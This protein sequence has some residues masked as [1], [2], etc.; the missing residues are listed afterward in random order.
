MK[1]HRR[2]ADH[3]TDPATAAL[4]APSPPRSPTISSSVEDSAVT[5]L[6]RGA[7]DG[8]P[9]SAVSLRT[10]IG[11]AAEAADVRGEPAGSLV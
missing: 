11:V 2:A 7:L 6:R 1:V 5:A 8:S 4:L 3:A 10:V 9:L